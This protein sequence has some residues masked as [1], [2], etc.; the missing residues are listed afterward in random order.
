MQR[1]RHATDRRRVLLTLT[2]LGVQASLEFSSVNE[3]V[4]GL[5]SDDARPYVWT[6]LEDATRLYVQLVGTGDDQASTS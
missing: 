5:V 6:F 4:A 2:K 1:A 3:Q